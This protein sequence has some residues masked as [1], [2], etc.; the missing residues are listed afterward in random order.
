MN[1]CSDVSLDRGSYYCDAGSGEPLSL[2]KLRASVQQ[3]QQQSRPWCSDCC[4][5]M[6]YC[7][8]SWCA[9]FGHFARTHKSA[10]KHRRTSHSR[11]GRVA[12][13]QSERERE[14]VS[15]PVPSRNL[16]I[17][18]IDLSPFSSAHSSFYRRLIKTN[19]RQLV[20][21]SRRQ[22]TL[23]NKSKQPTHRSTIINVIYNYFFL[24]C[25]DLQIAASSCR[26]RNSARRSS[27]LS[28]TLSLVSEKKN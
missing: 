18:W 8:V 28:S 7:G 10:G 2:I 3:Q 19:S 1:S 22:R 4:A 16:M 27:S 15:G 25:L 24:F 26:S 20:H 23:T 6:W 12:W 11:I 17:A 21:T 13:R 9:Q 14:Q 5:C